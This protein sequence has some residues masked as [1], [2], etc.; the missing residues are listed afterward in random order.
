M[1]IQPGERI[2]SVSIKRA[3]PGGGEDVDPSELFAKKRVVMFSLPGAFTPTCS[4]RHLPGYLERY[5][6]LLGQGGDLIACLSVND[7][8][9]MQAWAEAQGVGDRIVMLADGAGRFTRAL[10][11]EQDKGDLGMRAARALLTI[12]DGVVQS[13]DVEAPGKLE[14]S[15]AE[16]CLARL[17]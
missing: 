17:G 5:D 8:W 11:L 12:E 16:A 10:G 6:E 14:A 9:V 2:P 7:H 15:S 4:S 13:I 1:P 3:R